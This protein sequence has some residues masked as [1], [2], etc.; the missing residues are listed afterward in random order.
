MSITASDVSKLRAMTGAGMM[1]CKNALEEAEG[2]I[3]KASE[4]LR[5]KGIIKAAK[6]AG[7]TASEGLVQ[8]KVEGNTAVVVEVNSE[9]DFVAKN[10]DFKKVLDDLTSHVLNNKPSNVEEALNQAMS[11]QEGTV[12]DY[13]NDVTAKIGEKISLRRFELMEKD[14]NSAFGAYIHMHGK[15]GIL[16]VLEGSTD[17]EMARDISMHIAAS[18][19]LYLNREAVPAE[20]IE[21]EKE[22]YTAQ[23]KQQGKPENIIEN[24]LKGK[25]NKFYEEVCLVDQPFVKDDKK[26]VIEL[27]PEGVKIKSFVRYELGEGL[28]KK[29]C[30]FVAE[31]QEQID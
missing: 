29:S 7:K 27:L 23:L 21:K 1:D 15:M 18:N 19:P 5:K 31:V 22:V 24:I 8:V 14:D 9:T 6:R 10:E 17:E 2:D 28:E 3:E 20:V 26:K 25:I 11:D 4:V 16:T 12:Q 13:I 30:D